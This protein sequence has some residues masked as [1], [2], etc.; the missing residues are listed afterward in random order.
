M[1]AGKP[2]AEQGGRARHLTRALALAANAIV[3][4]QVLPGEAQQLVRRRTIPPALYRF[5][6]DWGL[7]RGTRAR[8]GDRPY[9]QPRG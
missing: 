1:Q 9:A 7:R 5:F 4:G 3:A 8:L 6:A 2:L